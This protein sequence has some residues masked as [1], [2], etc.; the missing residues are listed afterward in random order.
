MFITL[1][2]ILIYVGRKQ[3]QLLHQQEEKLREDVPAALEL[4][5]RGDKVDS[6]KK[7]SLIDRL[8]ALL[9][10]DRQELPGRYLLDSIMMVMEPEGFFSLTQSNRL[11]LL[12]IT[13]RIDRRDKHGIHKE[14]DLKK[15]EDILE[16]AEES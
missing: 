6:H 5:E 16:R 15:I 12:N 9:D 3:I 4:L 10:K 14:S 1:P 11:R 2:I 8:E 7:E 13:E